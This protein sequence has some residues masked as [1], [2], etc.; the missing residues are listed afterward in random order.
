MSSK[1]CF[2]AIAGALWLSGRTSEDLKGA[3][4][5]TSIQL[6]VC[7]VTGSSGGTSAAER[8]RG[9]SGEDQPSAGDDAAMLKVGARQLEHL[10]DHLV[11]RERLRIAL[12]LLDQAAH[13]VDHRPRPQIVRRDVG[14]NR[15]Q[16][17]STSS[18]GKLRGRRTAQK[19]SA[20]LRVENRSPAG[21]VLSWD[22]QRRSRCRVMV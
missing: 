1:S 10:A 15:T 11:D 7:G 14:E 4:L 18:L 16:L 12:A 3:S 9:R 22:V 5:A 17:G 20:D 13:A 2:T 6:E 21:V 8:R 19:V